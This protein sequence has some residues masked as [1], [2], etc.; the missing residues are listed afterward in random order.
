[1]PRIYCFQHIDCEGP[2][3]LADILR[4]KGAVVEILK[5]FKGQEIPEDLGD[6]LVIL[7]GPTAV[8]EEQENPW[9]T[10]ELA[11]IRQCMNRQKPV[12]GI[13]LGAQM[14]AH[15]AGG[16]VYKGSV[17][18]VGWHPVTLTAEAAGDPL[19]GGVPV[20]FEAFH[21]HSDTFD[22][23]EGA[24]RLAGSG[25]YP[26]QA[27][28]LGTKIYGIQFHLEVNRKMLEDWMLVY[29]KELTPQGGTIPPA[30]ILSSLDLNTS[31]LRAVADKV[32]AAFL[33]LF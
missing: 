30:N 4:S 9:M 23:P 6:G 5:P 16:R 14:L 32:F 15:L 31:R 13:C 17:S 33:S 21:W 22:L 26:N 20:N 2:G 25:R 1:M 12:L 27:F 7:G 19:L 8:Y 10:L 11:A 18:E 29:A 28:K 24:V 3:T